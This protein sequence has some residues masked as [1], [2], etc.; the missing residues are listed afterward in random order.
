MIVCHGLAPLAWLGIWPVD[1][2]DPLTGVT[3]MRVE[4]K[5]SHADQRDVN[6]PAA[7]A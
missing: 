2:A 1:R 3:V 6:G 7:A 5:P 4:G